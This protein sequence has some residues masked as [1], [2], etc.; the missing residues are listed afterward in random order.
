MGLGKELILEI[1]IEA[2]SRGAMLI[3]A[4]RLSFQ[5]SF[6]DAIWIDDQ[7][8]VI[9]DF[10]NFSMFPFRIFPIAAETHGGGIVYLLNVFILAIVLRVPASNVHKM[11]CW[12]L[13]WNGIWLSRK[14][15]LNGLK[16]VM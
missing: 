3:N 7:S 1:Y 13:E 2:F 14:F 10:L 5:A 15:V 16:R 8:F 6:S 12:L 4:F 11:F 9:T